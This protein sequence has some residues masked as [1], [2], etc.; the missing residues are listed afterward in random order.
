M[1][2][3]S[4]LPQTW[5]E[6]LD[7]Y[8]RLDRGSPSAVYPILHDPDSRLLLAAWASYLVPW[9][10]PEGLAPQEQDSRVWEWLWKG[11]RP[12]MARL[13]GLSGVPKVFIAR[14][15]RILRGA[16]LIFPDGTISAWADKI[17]QAEITLVYPTKRPAPRREGGHAE[18]STDQRSRR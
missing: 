17:L 5:R 2:D 7:H 15:L 10:P 13:E 14:K 9:K 8:K 1:P 11:C 4:L 6:A 3:P 16:R 12:S 18:A